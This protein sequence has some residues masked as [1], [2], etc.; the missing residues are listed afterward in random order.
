[1]A[2]LIEPARVLLQK[3]FVAKLAP[4][5]NTGGI[6]RE[7]AI[8][9]RST[10]V[11]GALARETHGEVRISLARGE[12]VAH[13]GDQNIS[14]LDVLLGNLAA[15]DLDRDDGAARIRNEKARSLAARLRHGFP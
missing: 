11:G 5:T 10:V 6:P 2:R 7:A 9:P 13:P 1:M 8:E 3:C 4:R 15:A 14:N 12:A